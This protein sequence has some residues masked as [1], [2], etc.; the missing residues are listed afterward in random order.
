MRIP[1]Q[2]HQAEP[3]EILIGLLDSGISQDQTA[4]LCHA[5]EFCGGP[6]PATKGAAYQDRLGHG[7][8]LAQV[9][10]DN[11]PQVQLCVAKIFDHQL[12]ANVNQVAAG[13]DWL[14]EQGV[15]IVNLSFGLR[16]DRQPLALACKRALAAG[17][18]L[19]AAS[20][21]MGEQVYP[22]NY[23]D[24]I[25]VTGDARCQSDQYSWQPSGQADLGACVRAGHSRVVGASVATA[26]ISA[27]VARFIQLHPEQPVN[28]AHLNGWLKENASY[29]TVQRPFT[30]IPVARRLTYDKET[31]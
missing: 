18:V 23:P 31:S 27:R 6:D 24:V 26:Y 9:M 17:V 8:V 30:A 22:A 25:R 19:V 5:V 29:Q 4:Q 16:Q 21:A 20:P 2:S 13:L 14:V 15:R 7:S 28:L 3:D 1:S 12:T 11:I 10:I